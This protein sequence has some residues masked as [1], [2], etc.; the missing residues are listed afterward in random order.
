MVKNYKKIIASYFQEHSFVEHNLE[1]FNLFLEK[2]LQNIINEVSEIVPTIIPQEY[3]NFKIKLGRVRIEKPEIVDADGSRRQIFPSEARLRKLTYSA[4]IYLEVSAYINDIQRDSFVTQIGKIPIMVKSKFC[5]LHGLKKDELIKNGEDPD[6]PGG[7]FIL[8]GNERA[9]IT[10]EDLASNKTFISEASTGPSQF[11]GKIYS[12]R[13]NYRIPHTIEQMKDRIFYL[14]FARFKRIPIIAIIK[15]LGLTKDQDIMLSISPDKIY[16][17]ILINLYNSVDLKTKEDAIEFIAKKIGIT[18]K[19]LREERTLDQLDKYLLPHL[20][21]TPK[22]RI[23][24][25]HNLCKFV[26]KFIMVSQENVELAT[27]DHYMNKR[28]KL[29]GDL[30]EDL[31]RVNIRSLIQDILYNFQ[32]LVKRGK[33]SSIRTVIREQLLTSRVKSAMAT[34][35]W[36]GS[37]AGITQNMA[38]TNAIDTISNLQRVVSLLTSTQENFEARALH[39][40][41]W[42]RLCPVETPE[43]QPIGLRKNLALM[44]EITRSEPSE[45]KIK[46]SLEAIG[47][48]PII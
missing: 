18:Q 4:P 2:G 25:A 37:R 40:T 43:G 47:L 1:S 32:R 39:A 36:P 21:V 20:G 33:F 29:A 14:S 8:N 16:D 9:M 41:H 34:G 44:A 46:K 24:K 7:Y 30:L 22:D 3:E 23:I 15:A 28:L 6:D 17:D 13:E 48:S 10:V 42:G 27:K 5:H 26:R 35:S 12:E 45:E 11:V 38:R 19:E 31:F